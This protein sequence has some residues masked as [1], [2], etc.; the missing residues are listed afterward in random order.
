MSAMPP[1]LPYALLLV[2]LA[3]PPAHA[4]S[5]EAGLNQL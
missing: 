2:T 4:Q 3:A 5:L 1:R